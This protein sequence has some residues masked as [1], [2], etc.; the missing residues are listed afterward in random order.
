M[1]HNTQTHYAFSI[2]EVGYSNQAIL[3]EQTILFPKGEWVCL[4][5]Q[6]GKGKTTFLKT[7]L[8]LL[9]GLKSSSSQVRMSYMSQND[10]LLP[11]KTILENV[12]LGAQ[13]RQQIPNFSKALDLLSAVGLED[14]KNLYP[15]QLSVGMRQ[16]AALVRTLMEDDEIVLMDEP[17]S[18]VDLKLREDLHLLTKKLLKEKTVFFVSH[19]LSEVL[20]L[21]DQ[22]FILKGEPATLCSLP[23]KKREIHEQSIA[24]LYKALYA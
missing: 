2:L 14:A 18:A 21:A 6:S 20:T 5:G 16:R 9:P 7:L 10:L 22:I 24:S 12:I 17:F 3:A 8:G 1:K 4:M 23:F 19:D 13:L 15:Y 11:W